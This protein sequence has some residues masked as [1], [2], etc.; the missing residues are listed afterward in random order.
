MTDKACST[1]GTGFECGNNSAQPCW[2]SHF[3]AIMPLAEGQDCRCPACLKTAVKE[4]IDDYL[5]QNPAPAIIPEHYKNKQLI[6]Y[7]DYYVENG[8]WV[9][10]AWFH[11][12]RGSC[13]GN[14][15]RHCPYDHMNVRK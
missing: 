2:C 4:K 11:C 3:P 13:C 12:K 1:C 15:C 5:Q 8:N 14:G 7:I 9:F 10:T 6:E